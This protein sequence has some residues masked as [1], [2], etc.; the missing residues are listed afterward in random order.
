M[1]VFTIIYDN[2]LDLHL[3]KK[4]S[5]YSIGSKLVESGNMAPYVGSRAVVACVCIFGQVVDSVG[6]TVYG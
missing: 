4:S 6:Y 1:K 2:I 3:Q 5:L